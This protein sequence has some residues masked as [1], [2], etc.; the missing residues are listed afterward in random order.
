M[1]DTSY[2]RKPNN[3]EVF[4]DEVLLSIAKQVAVGGVASGLLGDF[5][6]WLIP[7][8]SLKPG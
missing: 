3:G 2:V 8:L 4:S 7:W 1:S 6:L 5:T